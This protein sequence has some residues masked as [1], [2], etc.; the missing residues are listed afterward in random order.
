MTPLRPQLPPSRSSLGGLDKGQYSI[1]RGPARPRD[2]RLLPWPVLRL[3][4][5]G[6]RATAGAR[7]SRAPSCSGVARLAV[8]G[9]AGRHGRYDRRRLTAI[10]FFEFAANADSVFVA[11]GVRE[12]PG[13]G[14]SIGEATASTPGIS[15]AEARRRQEADPNT[16][17]VDVRD[18]ANW[19]ASDMA[20]GAIAVS[21]GT[22][23][24]GA[25]TEVPEA[26]R[27]A[28]WELEAGPLTPT[29]PAD[30]TTY[31][32]DPPPDSPSRSTT[33]RTTHSP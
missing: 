28:N 1:G 5:R 16:L 14:D 20:A 22:L 21:A 19:R 8:G 30:P 10:G 7:R 13:H 29:A 18:L 3:L 12:V 11:S 23:P 33:P 27:D 2:R 9:I 17:I 31:T 26:W 15:P 24:F 6:G 4:G 25:D 32:P